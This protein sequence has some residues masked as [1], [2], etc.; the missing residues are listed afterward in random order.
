MRDVQPVLAAER[1]QQVVARDAGHLLRLEAEQLADAVVLVHDEVAGAEVGER[2]E[3][4][5]AYPA[6][7]RNAA[8]EDLVIRQ[9]HEPELAP[10]EAAASGRDREQDL[11]LLRDRVARLEQARVDLAQQVL[12]AQRLAAVRERDDDAL[13]GAD[14][15]GQLVL[16]LAQPARRDRRPLRLEGERL[17]LRERV[18]LRRAVERDRLEPVLLPDPAH[19]VGL[20]DE[21]GSAGQRRHE[22]VRHRSRLAFLAVPFLDEIEAPLHG[23]ID[24]GLLHRMQ[25]A[26]RERREG[27]DRLDLVAE[28]LDAERLA[29]GGREEIDEPAADG[30]L[31]AVVDALDALV[32][33]EGEHL[34]QPLDPDLPSGTQL[35]RLGPR[36][37]GRQPLRNRVCGRA[38]EPAA[39]QH[40]ERTRPLAHEMRRRLQPRVP[41]DAAA[42]HEAD[43]LLAEEPGGRLGGVARV[44]I[45]R[46]Q[47][48]ERPIELLVQRRDHDRQRRLGH[49]RLRRQRIRELGKPLV[50]DELGDEGV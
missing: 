44:R 16:R 9:Q 11:R 7:A 18:E 46:E 47:A 4:A 5:A 43:T 33:G 50:L 35:E 40:V 6:L 39:R 34:G 24:D 29:P 17:S 19:V 36:L 21:V 37:R 30:E 20:E 14:E 13:A 1:E 25:R 27:A 15:R 10:D 23:G 42:G 45:L 3:R 12:R 48:D 28:E 32:A 8:T 41:F 38:D 49:A 2:L 22:I 26:L 31:A